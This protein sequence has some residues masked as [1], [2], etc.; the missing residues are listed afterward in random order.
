MLVSRL[1]YSSILKIEVTFSSETSV[2]FQQTTRR[3][4]PENGN[5]QGSLVLVSSK[6]M[7]RMERQPQDTEEFF[8]TPRN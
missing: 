6:F 1:A 7:L 8:T 4:T 2:Q 5:L 3:Y